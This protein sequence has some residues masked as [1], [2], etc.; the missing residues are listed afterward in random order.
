MYYVVGLGNPGE[1]YEGT[2]HNV[3][4]AAVTALREAVH[5]PAFHTS[6]RFSGLISTGVWCEKEVTLLLPHTYMNKSGKAVRKL[7]AA[8]GSSAT[9]ATVL[10]RLI[11]VHDDIDLPLGT[12]R[13]VRGRGAG[14]NNGVESIIQAL[15]SKDFIRLRVGIAPTH[16]WSGEIQRPTGG[17]PLE[18]YV[19]QRFGPLERAKLPAI[20]AQCTQALE[21]IVTRGVEAAMNECNQS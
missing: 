12:V 16:W 2:R 1:R 14:E 10:K 18:K 9:P 4:A 19:L 15:G 21:L 3:G 6:A 20:Y 11:I 7:V 17:G 8:D 5:L 13:V